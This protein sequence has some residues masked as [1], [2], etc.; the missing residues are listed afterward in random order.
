MIP[1]VVV[2]LILQY[3]IVSSAYIISLKK[4]L[5]DGMSLIEIKYS[6]GESIDL[7]G[8]PVVIGSLFDICLS[9]LTYCNRSE[10]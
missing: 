7:W 1:S 8:T 3:S 6:N 2:S 10:R 9:N 4:L 5:I